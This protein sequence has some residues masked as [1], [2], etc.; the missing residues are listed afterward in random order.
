V[1]QTNRQKGLRAPAINI[2]VRK[3]QIHDIR[4]TTAAAEV[5]YSV[6]SYN[7]V[8]S[9]GQ[10]KERI[11]PRRDHVDLSLAKPNLQWLVTNV[12]DLGD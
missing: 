2:Q 6:S 12:F 3:V 5:A 1:I 7:L 8:N 4:G 9:S 10:P 11:R